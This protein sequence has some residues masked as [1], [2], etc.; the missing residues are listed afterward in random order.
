MQFLLDELNRFLIAMTR[1]H[2]MFINPRRADIG[3][4]QR[5][6]NLRDGMMRFRGFWWGK[7]AA[8]STIIRVSSQS[9]SA[10]HTNEALLTIKLSIHS[11]KWRVWV[12]ETRKI[13]QIE[14]FVWCNL[15]GFVTRQTMQLFQPRAAR[16]NVADS[17]RRTTC[18]TVSFC[19][20]T[21]SVK[22]P[23]I[24]ILLKIQIPPKQ[25]SKW[26]QNL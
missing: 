21:A 23:N 3:G 10:L 15:T 5:D 6:G 17:K 22:P 14:L 12:A 13:L 2:A 20:T 16:R 1:C 24:L 9:S 4:N 19:R 11:T 18:W 26:H 8:V 7:R 25:R